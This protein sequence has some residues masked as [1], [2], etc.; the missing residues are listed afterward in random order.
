LRKL[1]SKYENPID[2]C[3][4]ILVENTT[5]YFHKLNFTP[6]MLTTIGVSFTGL[7]LY[8]IKNNN[9]RNAAIYY[10]IS[11]IFD[12]YDGYYA[13]KYNMVTK[14]GDYYDHI[15]D[16]TKNILLFYVLYKKNPKRTIKY[17]PIVILLFVFALVHLKYQEDYYD[18][19]YE[20]KTLNFNHL[21]GIKKVSKNVAKRKLRY[22]RYFGCG[23]FYMAITMMILS[24]SNHSQK[25]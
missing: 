2:N 4:Y 15:H 8:S 20:S 16:V 24:Y 17:I 23:T 11:Y 1:P 12:C 3:I 7:M 21:L 5:D 9:Y 18:R 6:N 19:H 22:T 14:F 10:M 13:R 25:K